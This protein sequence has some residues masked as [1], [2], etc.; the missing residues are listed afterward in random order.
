MKTT[1][2][3]TEDDENKKLKII[4]RKTNLSMDPH[5]PVP[6]RGPNEYFY[7]IFNSQRLWSVW[8]LQNMDDPRGNI[9]LHYGFNEI[10]RSNKKKVPIPLVTASKEHGYLHVYK[11]NDRIFFTDF[12]HN[13]SRLSRSDR[14][15]KI[16][17][18]T[19]QLIANDILTIEDV[20]FKLVRIPTIIISDDDDSESSNNR[21]G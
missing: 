5:T 15:F 1:R 7:S 2:K 12:S 21:S 17:N 18:G 9:S 16:H 6:V 13:G 11:R 3:K 14:M 8:M 19:I 4:R 10:G 20:S